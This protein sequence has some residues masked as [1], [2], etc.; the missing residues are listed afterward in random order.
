MKTLVM[1]LMVFF[2]AC[3]NMQQDENKNDMYSFL[4]FAYLAKGDVNMI[5]FYE[6]TGTSP[7]ICWIG[8]GRIMM[9]P[10]ESY[11]PNHQWNAGKGLATTDYLVANVGVISIWMPDVLVIS[12]GLFDCNLS[13]GY[14]NTP[15][16]IQWAIQQLKPYISKIIIINIIP[17][18]TYNANIQAVNLKIQ[19]VCIDEGVIWAD[20]T[21]MENPVDVL[22]PA[23]VYAHVYYNTAGNNAFITAI[24]P[25]L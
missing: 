9:L 11:F 1:F 22:N 8:D 25:Y 7:S 21:G 4:T 15:A 18:D 17:T 20:L 5:S 6:K 10:V 3:D 19:Q 2:F 16:K 14:T 13:D 12:I 23:Y 24:T